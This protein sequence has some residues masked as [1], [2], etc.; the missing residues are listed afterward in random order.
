[1]E[2]ALMASSKLLRWLS[3]DVHYSLPCLHDAWCEHLS[4]SFLDIPISMFWGPLGLLSRLAFLLFLT[5]HF[6]LVDQWK[7]YVLMAP[8][9]LLN[10]LCLS[11]FCLDLLV[12]LYYSLVNQNSCTLFL[13]HKLLSVLACDRTTLKRHR[14]LETSWS[15]WYF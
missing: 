10:H 1:M 3:D 15:L 12:M 2:M 11:A 9:N 14:Q 4:V 7:G 8:D 5:T 13:N 6:P